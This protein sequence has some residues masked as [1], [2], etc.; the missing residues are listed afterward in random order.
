MAENTNIG[1]TAEAWADIVIQRWERKIIAQ[2]ITETRELLNSFSHQIMVDAAGNPNLIQFAFKYYGKFVDM[3]VGNGVKVGFGG[4]SNRKAKPWYSKTF[5]A[6]VHKL[7]QILADK[8]GRKATL[9][10]IENI[11]DNAL[12]H[13]KSWTTI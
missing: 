8:Y 10:I 13:K 11:D 3:G 9:V 6:Q 12:K 4:K 2:H 1:L 5:A 7:G